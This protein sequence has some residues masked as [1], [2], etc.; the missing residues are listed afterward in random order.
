MTSTRLGNHSQEFDLLN[1]FPG[2]IPF[3]EDNGKVFFGRDVEKERLRELLQVY[4]TVLLH[5]QSGAGKTSLVSA[6]LVPLLREGGI[7]TAQF[8]VGGISLSSL[9]LTPQQNAFTTA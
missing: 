5:A 6:G 7:R 2:P 1:L 8:R 9:K 4:R 3:T